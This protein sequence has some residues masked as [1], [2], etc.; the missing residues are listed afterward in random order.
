MACPR[1]QGALPPVGHFCHRCGFDLVAGDGERR[2]SYA[3][4]PNQP[5]LSFAPVSTIMPRGSAGHPRTYSVAL[6]ATLLIMVLAAA[7]GA[8][9]VAL[10]VAA[11]A[12]PI[13]YVVYLYDVNLWKDAP[14][15]VTLLA[16]GLTFVLGLGWTLAWQFLQGPAPISVR[17]GV[18]D[19]FH[20][21]GFLVAVLLAPVVGEVI[22]Q[23]GPVVLASRKPFDDLLDGFTF[24]VIAGVAYAAA[25][26]IVLYWAMAAIGFAGPGGVDPL[27]LIVLLLLHGFVKP[28]VYGTATGIAGAEFSGLGAGF[29][30]FSLRWLRAAGLAVGV[31]ALFNAG[32][33]LSGLIP[34]PAVAV[35]AALLWAALLVAVLVPV[36]R[37]VLH[38]GLLEAALEASARDSGIGAD[39]ELGFC[40]QCEMPLRADSLFCSNCGLSVGAAQR[41]GPAA[42]GSPGTSKEEPS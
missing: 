1:C 33:A 22:R 37:N 28:V 19:G 13:V 4:Q 30:G 9:P 35:I 25:E 41:V 2:R 40:G 26:T 16:F 15:P 17:P 8:A 39:G 32:L 3:A 14:V 7:L 6:A 42:A 11:F 18:G 34:S 29:D 10:M 31:V 36:A 38:V 24:G 5:V 21:Q 12:I 23:L 27:Q 20:L